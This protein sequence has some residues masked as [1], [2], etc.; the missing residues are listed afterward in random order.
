M[1]KF[2]LKNT[3]TLSFL[4]ETLSNAN[5][6]ALMLSASSSVLSTGDVPKLA[7]IIPASTPALYKILNVFK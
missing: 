2:L 1:G 3:I 7:P 4:S 6:P 5:S